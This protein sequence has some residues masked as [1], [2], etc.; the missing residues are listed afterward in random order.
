MPRL[1]PIQTPRTLLQRFAYWVTRRQYGVVLTPMQVIYSRKPR[2]AFLAQ[3]IGS[4]MERGLSLDGDLVVLATSRVA[5]INGCAFCQDF[6][7]AKA[8]RKRIGAERF[9]GLAEYGT[10]PL[11]T[12]RE[13]AA[14][15]FCEQAS[16]EHAVSDRR[17]EAVR[18]HFRDDEIV[19]LAWIAA[20]ETYFNIQS[21]V[22]RL[23]SDRLAERA[24]EASASPAPP[25]PGAA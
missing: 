13:R 12:E 2:F 25:L 17:F 23:P 22:L 5:Q 1:A 15:A 8:I 7:L 19:E 18:E 11:F 20:A 10:S 3:H 4:T 16:R 24:A 21:S 9:D 14:L 6:A